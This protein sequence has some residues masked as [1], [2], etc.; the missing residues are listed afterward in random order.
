MALV[1][2]SGGGGGSRV[3]RA[4]TCA[5]ARSAAHEAAPSSHRL[6]D[7]GVERLRALPHWHWGA[8]WG[9]RDSAT[10]ITLGVG[11]TGGAVADAVCRPY[12]H[13]Q[14]MRAVGA[15]AAHTVYTVAQ[16]AECSLE[17]ILIMPKLLTAGQSPMPR[18]QRDAM[19]QV[20]EGA[21]TVRVGWQ[22]S[23][24]K[25]LTQCREAQPHGRERTRRL[26]DGTTAAV[27]LELVR[28]T[29]LSFAAMALGGLKVGG[30]SATLLAACCL[31]PVRM[32]AVRVN[33]PIRIPRRAALLNT[34]FDP[35]LE[36]HRMPPPRVEPMLCWSRL[37]CAS[38]QRGPRRPHRPHR[39]VRVRCCSCCRRCRRTSLLMPLARSCT[40][41]ALLCG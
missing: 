14:A 22:L 23:K 2:C 11:S 7:E 1:D 34:S 40:L 5:R 27:Y 39:A 10:H 31:S 41:V 37:A 29:A 6:T 15:A 36:A 30:F 3:R 19:T 32:P 13:S 18:G 28:T 24:R 25:A 35:S 12:E 26:D 8:H 20:A 33:P 17:A 4:V 9:A 21:V 16:P 38:Q